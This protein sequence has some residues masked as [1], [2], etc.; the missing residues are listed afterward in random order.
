MLRAHHGLNGELY[1]TLGTIGHTLQNK[2]RARTSRVVLRHARVTQITNQRRRKTQDARRNLE[3]Y[4]VLLFSFAPS[5]SFHHFGSG[6]RTSL[7]VVVAENKQCKIKSNQINLIEWNDKRDNLLESMLV[8]TNNQSIE[9]SIKQR[10]ERKFVDDVLVERSVA[11]RQERSFSAE[12]SVDCTM[13]LVRRSMLLLA[14]HSTIGKRAR[15]MVI[16][17]IQD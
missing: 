14:G 7:A 11:E 17:G 5:Q 10:R 2:I 9:Q 3:S 15:K 12:K 1:S 4:L 8:G 6:T 16:F 13:V